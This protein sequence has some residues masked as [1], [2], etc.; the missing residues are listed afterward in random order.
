MGLNGQHE[1]STGTP[2]MAFIPF[3]AATTAVHRH[4]TASAQHRRPLRATPYY[5]QMPALAVR[6]R[7]FVTGTAPTTSSLSAAPTLRQ[8]RRSWMRMGPRQ[9]QIAVITGASSGIGLYA[10]KTLAS[11]GNWHVILACRDVGRAEQAAAQAQLPR[12]TY[13]TMPCDLAS[14]ESVRAFARNLTGQAGVDHVDALVCNAAIWYPR[15]KKP[16]F[17][18]DGIEETAQVCHLS[19]VLLCQELLSKLKMSRGRVVFL[20][21]Q[22]HSPGTLPGMIP[23]Q[24]N[25][26]DMSG[27]ARGLGP[28]TTGMIDNGPFEPTKAY[29]DAKAANVLTMRAMNAR[30]NKDGVTSVAVFPGCVADTNLFREKRAWFRRLFFPLLQK[31]IT[32]QYVPNEEAGRRVAEVASQGTFSDSGSYYQ[33]RGN[34]FAGRERTRPEVIQP[35]GEVVKADR[36]YELSLEVIDRALRKKREA[37]PPLGRLDYRSLAG[38]T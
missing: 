20:T 34:Y 17:T 37:Q 9:S 11:T 18:V 31:Y 25:L 12:D 2:P 3:T 14:F 28:D 5:A 16:R 19:H 15:D 6:A 27:L 35:T 21:T 10:A 23:P 8:A 36:L 13:T 26:G 7:A 33:W 24:A 38:A 32:R 1:T 29:K 22:T 30:F 4:G